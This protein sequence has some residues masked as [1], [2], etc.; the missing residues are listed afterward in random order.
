MNPSSFFGEGKDV[1]KEA[2]AWIEALD[3]YFMLINTSAKNESMIARYKLTG[4]AK[5]WWK[6]WCREQTIDK[7]TTTWKLIK[8][9]VKERYLPLDHETFKMNEVYGLTQKHLSV[10]AYYSEF[11]KLKRYAPPMTKPQAI[12]RFMRGLNPPLNHCLKSMRP[13]SL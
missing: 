2:E 8:E 11:V 3:D 6:E 5:L 10:D 4:E 9:A 13:E 7:T 12:S 1:A